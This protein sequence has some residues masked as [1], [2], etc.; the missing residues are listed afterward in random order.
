M[1][2]ESD[3]SNYT[4]PQ[5]PLHPCLF[6]SGRTFSTFVPRTN[7]CHMS[8]HDVTVMGCSGQNIDDIAKYAVAPQ[9]IDVCV[10][11]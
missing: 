2:G 6:P 1:P 7:P 4:L 10:P 3:P 8:I 11:Y 5:Q 9:P